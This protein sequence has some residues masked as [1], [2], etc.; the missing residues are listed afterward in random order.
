MS[1]AAEAARRLCVDACVAVQWVVSEPLTPQ[2]LALYQDSRNTPLE[3]IVPTLLR[4]EVVSAVYKRTWREVLP[5]E[6]ISLDEARQLIQRFHSFQLQEETYSDIHLDAME[7][8]H[9]LGL[10]HSHDA[11]YLALARRL[12]C[13]LWT[14]DQR[15]WNA[16]RDRLDGVFWLGDY[17]L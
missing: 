17:P 14:A 1:E 2:A 12:G 13:D 8:A 15:L 16:V 4:F 7:L 6:L 9:L 10:R 11:H 5:G 3:I